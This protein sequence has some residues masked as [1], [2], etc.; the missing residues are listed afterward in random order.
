MSRIIDFHSH[1]LPGIDD[2]SKNMEQSISMLKKS[3]EQG[4]DHIVATPHFYA[5]HDDPERFL[6][7][8]AEA[9]TQLR[10][11]MAGLEGVPSLG[12]GAEVYYFNGIAD[13]DALLEL[14]INKKRYILIEMPMS[15]WTDRMYRDLE[16][17][18]IKQGL[19][20]VIAH[21]DR[22]ISPFHSRGILE[23][24]EHMPV[25][26]QANAN[27]FIDSSTRRMALKMLKKEK[28]HLLGSD[29]H[30]LTDRAPNLGEAVEIICKK[31]GQERI[32]RIN[33]F[34]DEVLFGE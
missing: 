14:T 3:A 21:I 10:E 4:V 32:N 6:R 28:I 25:L 15:D 19:M 34:E 24:L 1:I 13:S 7:R 26:I 20:P 17:I 16:G 29:C 33:Y 11:A 22:Y 30:N 2:G 8:R 5:H 23:R 31:L 27:F 9:E 18:W 12:I